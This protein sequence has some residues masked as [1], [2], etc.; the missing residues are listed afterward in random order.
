MRFAILCV[1]AA[2]ALALPAAAQAKFVSAQDLHKSCSARQGTPG[3][4]VAY[5]GCLKYISAIADSVDEARIIQGRRACIPDGMRDFQ[6]KEI[7]AD[8][9]SR[10]PE[11]WHLPAPGVVKTALTQN[12]AS[13]AP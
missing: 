8:Y 11:T 6:V 4:I 9:L 3:F 7:V 1:P 13:C 12:I 2:L 5:A 10:H